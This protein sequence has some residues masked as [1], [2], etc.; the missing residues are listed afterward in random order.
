MLCSM[1]MQPRVID[2]ALR[3]LRTNP[4]VL[5]YARSA[6]PESGMSVDDI[7]LDA[8][9]RLRESAEA[10]AKEDVVA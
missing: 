4:E 10:V 7:L 9:R 8:V 5:E 2:A 6:A 1:E 3:F